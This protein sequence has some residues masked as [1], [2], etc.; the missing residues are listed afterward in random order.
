MLEARESELEVREKVLE[1]QK[2]LDSKQRE[3]D[4]AQKNKES[5]SGKPD[6]IN[7]IPT[8][9][10]AKKRRKSGDKDAYENDSE[11]YAILDLVGS[12]SGDSGYLGSA[13][14]LGEAGLG[15]AN[16]NSDTSN[17][18]IQKS[19]AR[20]LKV[21]DPIVRNAWLQPVAHF[22]GAM[23]YRKNT[24]SVKL[25][26]IKQSLIHPRKEETWALYKDCNLSCCASN[27]ENHL[28][29]QYEIVEI[30]QRNSF[31]TR[32]ASLD[33]L[34][35][36]ASL[37][38]RRCHNK[39]DTFLIH[40]EELFKFSHKVRSFGMSSRKSEGVSEGSFELDPK[41]LPAVFSSN[42]EHP[43]VKVTKSIFIV[44]M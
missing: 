1:L 39:K 43:G 40:D 36:Y 35:G 11:Q 10:R 9:G 23:L 38:H 33:K 5:C 42:L 37:Y 2:V 31:D 20:V 13:H 4:S 24:K 26:A 27:P 3:L 6:S 29:C 15:L 34:E 22:P 25:P 44:F 12:D 17:D 16:S 7:P 21:R 8:W 28:S 18:K 41:S 14:D 19:Y 30:V 32:V